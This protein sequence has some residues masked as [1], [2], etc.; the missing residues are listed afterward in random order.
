[1]KSLGRIVGVAIL[2]SMSAGQLSWAIRLMT[3]CGSKM[4]TS[5]H[6]DVFI[7]HRNCCTWRE[8]HSE[9]PRLA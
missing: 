2:A 3:V 6:A 8:I 7:F 9:T 1:M 5:A 4:K